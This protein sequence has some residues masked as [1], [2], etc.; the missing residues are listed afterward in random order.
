M[1]KEILL[2]SDGYLKEAQITLDKVLATLWR[3]NEKVPNIN[4][5]LMMTMWTMVWPIVESGMSLLELSQKQ[6]MR[7]CLSMF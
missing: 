6:R 3:T 5:D 1:N 2:G 7:D 4:D